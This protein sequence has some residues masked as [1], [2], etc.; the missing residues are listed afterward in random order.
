MTELNNNMHQLGQSN[1]PL[2]PERKGKKDVMVNLMDSGGSS[3]EAGGQDQGGGCGGHGARGG[4]GGGT[5]VCVR[6]LKKEAVNVT[7]V[8]EAERPK[9]GMNGE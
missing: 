8:K 2:L 7:E 5:A 3:G 9:G 6:K 1:F 4:H